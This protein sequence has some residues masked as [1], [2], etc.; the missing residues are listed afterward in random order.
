MKQT[1]P[2]VIP[3]NKTKKPGSPPV[4]AKGRK[5]AV[6][7]PEPKP[8]FTLQMKILTG[9]AIVVIVGALVALL[10]Q[11]QE[12][13]DQDDQRRALETAVAST[14][15]VPPPTPRPGSDFGIS[16]GILG[17]KEYYVPALPDEKVSLVIANTRQRSFWVSNCDGVLLQRF[18]GTDSND[19]NQTGK[20]ENWETI[21]PGG[22]PFCGPVTGR[23][24]RQVGP[25]VRADATF[26]FDLRATRPFPNKNWDVPGTYRLL[27]VYYL[28]CP[29]TSDKIV[30]CEEKNSAESDYFKIVS[31][32]SLPNFTPGAATTLTPG[33]TVAPTPTKG[34]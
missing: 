24:A 18:S 11:P 5:G 34:S 29:S 16:I 7:E 25:G 4:A 8:A 26:K 1:K 32:Q 31:P 28:R 9:L 22:F 6:A 2:P 15:F 12:R 14:G 17:A 30:D 20:A 21:A 19:K 3:P 10:S 23:V 13:I 27:V 33:P